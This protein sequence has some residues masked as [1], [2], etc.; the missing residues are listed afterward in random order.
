[1]LLQMHPGNEIYYYSRQAF[2]LMSRFEYVSDR[3]AGFIVEHHFDKKLLNFLPLLRRTNIRQFW[4]CKAV[5][6]DLSPENKSL[7]RW[8][9]GTY[10]MRS[11]N[12][13]PYIELGT[14]LDNLFRYFRLDCVWRFAPAQPTNLPPPPPR[15]KAAFGV[16]GSVHLQF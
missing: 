11:L 8:E 10:H 7:N 2:N 9:Y 16:F 4:N 3:Y 13:R 5:W 15:P 6:G 1:M 12:G 14:G